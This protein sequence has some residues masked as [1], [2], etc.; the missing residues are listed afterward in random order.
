MENNYVYV[1]MAADIIHGGHI[2]ILENASKYGTVIVGLLSDDAIK[3]YKRQPI[4]SYNNRKSVIESIKYVDKVV[5]QNTHSYVNN[6]NKIQ[7]K[8]VIHGDDWNSG[9]QSSVREDV[10]NTLMK[11]DGK[12]IEIPYTQGISTTDIINK[13]K[14]Q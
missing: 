14:F 1:G 13:I 4:I 6:L 8:Y 5:E 9:V 10:I 12:L 3:S 2:N 11:W 7:P